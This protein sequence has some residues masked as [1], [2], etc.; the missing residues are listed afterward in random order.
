MKKEYLYNTKPEQAFIK[1]LK[2]TSENIII[3]TN[4]ISGSGYW[5][6]SC[7]YFGYSMKAA[8]ELL[9]ADEI[10]MKNQPI[11][12]NDE[13]S[14]YFHKML[15]PLINSFERKLRKL[16]YI[17]STLSKD[18]EI[19]KQII[20][21]ESKD[22]G[23][24]FDLLFT[25]PDFV[26]KIKTKINRTTWPFSKNYLVETVKNEIENTVWEKLFGLDSVSDLYKNFRAVKDLRND[27][28]HA[29]NF[30]KATYISAKSLFEKINNQL[31]SKINEL[32]GMP[33]NN[34]I[35]NF[36]AISKLNELINENYSLREKQLIRTNSRKITKDYLE[37]IVNLSML[38]LEEAPT[39]I[40][41]P[42]FEQE[43]QQDYTNDL[44][45]EKSNIISK[46]DNSTTE[47]A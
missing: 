41:A 8:I 45:D 24:I 10:I 2:N 5:I 37:S 30:T 46:T 13:I 39:K 9:K 25:D 21:L 43:L 12:I 32:I 29:H 4:E 14:A 15:F 17:A 7:S 38:I 33:A 34:K 6:I 36:S 16:L 27:V 44:L 20:D 11:I 31:E 42:F 35:F 22:L 26:K 47:D 28:M 23:V 18:I 1:S 40:E 19:K 3:L